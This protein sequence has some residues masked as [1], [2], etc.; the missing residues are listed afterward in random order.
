MNLYSCIS[1]LWCERR[2]FL[3]I[4]IYTWWKIWHVIHS[5]SFIKNLEVTDFFFKIIFSSI[6]VKITVAIYVSVIFQCLLTL[7]INH[8]DGYTN[9]SKGNHL[10]VNIFIHL[11]WRA[12]H[13]RTTSR[14]GCDKLMVSYQVG[15]E[16]RRGA[17]GRVDLERDYLKGSLEL[18][19]RGQYTKV[20]VFFPKGLDIRLVRGFIGLVI[21]LIW[22]LIGRMWW[23][24]MDFH[25]FKS[26]K[27]AQRKIEI[28]ENLFEIF[29]LF[30]ALT[31]EFTRSLWLS[32]AFS[33]H[34]VLHC[35]CH[36]HCIAWLCV[37]MLL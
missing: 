8:A 20:F 9:E 29:S 34:V 3:C 17:R 24:C 2:S 26:F 19:P 10:H 28:I 1:L 30:L 7:Q 5:S 32:L 22:M 15:L 36:L 33:L 13:S 37:V 12:E 18:L 23:S 21:S 6:K 14:G 27:R 16:Q 35:T 25:I 11:T 31:R 4:P